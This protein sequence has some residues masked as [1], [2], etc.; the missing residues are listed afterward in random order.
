MLD[1]PRRI[2]SLKINEGLDS[3][4][5][6]WI[7]GSPFTNG[8]YYDSFALL[9]F[10]RGDVESGEE[11]RVLSLGCAAGS[12]LRVLRAV[13]GEERL[14]AVGVDLDPDVIEL[15]RKWFG[16]PEDGAR[17]RMVGNLDARVYVERVREHGE[18]FDLI[19]VDTYRNQIYLPPHLTSV[20]F[21]RAVRARLTKA[22]VVALNV[23]D[24]SH[25][26]PVISAVA[27]TLAA[28]F[29]C[30]ESFRVARAR[31][32]LLFGHS[33][34]P[35]RMPSALSRSRRPAGLS[36][37]LWGHAMRPGAY[38]TWKGLPESECLTDLRSN[39]GKLHERIYGRL[40]VRVQ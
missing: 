33:G 12:I 38:R 35:G 10:L 21:F 11:L 23:G 22:G 37:K 13:V 6:V 9:P 26:G 2:R 32:F 40:P 4:H 19:C 30:V 29:P 15:G 14:A 1:R 7:D 8:R 28:V 18:L 16:L 25:E 20:E 27:G 5:S 31:N 36:E 24:L 39:L 34:S 17:Q 3:Y